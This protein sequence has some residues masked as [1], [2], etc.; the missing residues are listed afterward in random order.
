VRA[1]ACSGHH[2]LLTTSVVRHH[3]RRDAAV[4]QEVSVSCVRPSL[5]R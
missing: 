3:A 2:K 1:L 5:R 4:Q